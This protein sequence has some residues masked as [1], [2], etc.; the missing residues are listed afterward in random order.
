MKYIKIR[1][2]FQLMFLIFV[3]I[4]ANQF[5]NG[6]DLVHSRYQKQ[7]D[8]IH[9]SLENIKLP[10][11]MEENIYQEF[12]EFESFSIEDLEKTYSEY[13]ERLIHFQ[14]REGKLYYR[15]NRENNHPVHDYTI[16]LVKL[17]EQPGFHI[18]NGDFLIVPW[19]TAYKQQSKCPILC[20]SK[21]K[22]S[23]YVNI[24]DWFSL[25][26][27]RVLLM[28]EIDRAASAFPWH[29]KKEK[30]FWIGA[31]NGI[32]DSMEAFESNNRAQLVVFSL[33]YPELIWARF[34]SLKNGA[35]TCPEVRAMD[36]LL[37][38]EQERISEFNACQ[39]KYLIDVDGWGA[40]FH[41]CHW[42]LRSN[43]VPI[44]ENSGNLQWYYSGLKPYVH[45]VPYE[46]DCSD[47]K[48][49]LQWLKAHNDQAKQIAL[50]GRQFAL[51]YLNSDMIYLY[52][53]NVLIQYNKLNKSI[54]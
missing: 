36:S 8:E 26:Q 6:A 17:L 51:D 14:I 23:N 31:A 22:E 50:N 48:E 53:Y 7:F 21:H 5:Y 16:F 4:H 35:H 45:Y 44:K 42:I 37:S 24:P 2:I 9:I 38:D 10:D 39:Y 47:L 54:A 41:R 40:A 28:Q 3:S 52:L 46:T 30:G 43:S 15:C 20:F 33:I 1:F 12:Q 25:S 19:D 29:M 18:E 11:W 32:L 13:P 34:N 49:V 27:E